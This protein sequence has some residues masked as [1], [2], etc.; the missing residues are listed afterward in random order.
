MSSVENAFGSVIVTEFE[1]HEEAH[2]A[3]TLL[4]KSGFSVA[5]V[6]VH[7]QSWLASED[8]EGH[9]SIWQAV[10]MA[11]KISV[12]VSLGL[13]MLCGLFSYYINKEM[14]GHQ[15]LT[16]VAIP[17]VG[18]GILGVFIGLGL[19]A[20]FGALFNHAET[21]SWVEPEYGNDLREGNFLVLLKAPA[22]ELQSAKDSVDPVHPKSIRV[23]P[24]AYAS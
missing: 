24:A 3:A 2:R 15:S 10:A 22:E 5:N 23:M 4:V 21:P 7:G 17:M 11:L 14:G 20:G 18:L 8:P 12:P 13:G 6:T 16:D 1:N 9:I 19:G